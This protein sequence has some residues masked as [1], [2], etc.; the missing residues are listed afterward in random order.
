MR[1]SL[2]FD[3]ADPIHFKYQLLQW[4]AEHEE[5]LWLDSNQHSDPYGSFDAILAM[6]AEQS[7]STDADGSFKA[8]HDFREEIDDWIFGYLSY[9]LKNDI[10]AMSS[11]GLDELGFPDL[12]FFQPKKI[13]RLNHSEAVFSYLADYQNEIQNDFRVIVSLGVDTEATIAPDALRIRSRISRDTYLR[14]V[15]EFLSHIRRGDIYEAN[16]CQEFY[17]ENARIDPL[18]LYFQLNA[19]SKPPFAAYMRFGSHYALSASPERFL[20]KKGP[21]LV[22]QPIKGTAKRSKDPEKDTWLKDSLAKDRKELSENIM[23]TDLVRNDLSKYAVKGSVGVKELCQVY[24]FEQVHQM[25]STVEAQA[26]AE[27]NPVDIIK[28]AFPMGSM[29]GAPKI[30]AMKLI[31]R[32]EVNRRGL[33]SGALGY[34]KPDG[35]FDFNV[36][37]RTILYNADRQYLSFS[38]G[39]AINSSSVSEKE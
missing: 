29:T 33:Y 37:I 13:I 22:S 23:I 12:C 6:G 35:D 27:A 11:K 26:R 34:F 21:R 1:C 3:L 7:L 15:E 31:E 24:T 4:A 5:I 32:H 17:A 16:Y 39:S 19:I 18:Q 25:I 14:K 28:A 2:R 36:V 30:S 8:L 20:M 38:V 10:E 9:D